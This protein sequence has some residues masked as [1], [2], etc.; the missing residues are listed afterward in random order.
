MRSSTALWRRQVAVSGR[1]LIS[2][3]G[4]Q[5]TTPSGE[6]VNMADQK[7]RTLEDSDIVSNPDAER[8]VSRRSML[9]AVGTIAIGGAA[10]TVMAGC[11]RRAVVVG[12][13]APNAVVVAPQVQYQQQ[14]WTSGVTDSDGGPYADPAGN[15]RGA[16]RQQC[17]GITDSDG[18]PGADPGG[19]G[20]GR[21]GM[22]SGITDSDGGAYADPAGNGR[23]NV[24]QGYTGITDSDGGPY[25]DPAG[26]GR[27]RWR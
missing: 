20:R 24:R 1:S 5:Q 14:Q 6:K 26:S 21:M 23:G 25:A 12:P 4:N 8:E 17:S 11:Y 27:G 9:G 13:R 10:S 7:K 22:T 3:K 16:H 18:G 2:R 15:G 19:C